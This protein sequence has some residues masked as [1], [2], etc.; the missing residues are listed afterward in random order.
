MV[1]N[2][3]INSCFGNLIL[4]ARTVTTSLMRRNTYPNNKRFDREELRING[5]KITIKIYRKSH[6][7]YIQQF[8]R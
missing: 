2:F 6:S 8:K 7:S 1:S 5:I 3:E 4:N